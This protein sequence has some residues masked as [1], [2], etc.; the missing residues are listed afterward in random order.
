MSTSRRLLFTLAAPLAAVVFALA[1]SAL[2]LVVSGHNPL[3]AFRELYEYLTATRNGELRNQITIVNRAVPLYLA[4]VAVAI[5]F[6]MNLFNIGVEGQ[7]RFAGLIAA[8]VGASIALPAVIHLPV[9]ILTA[10]LVGALWAGLA[11]LLKVGRGVSEVI[12]TIM[13]NY[14]AFALIQWLLQD[15]LRSTGDAAQGLGAKTDEI[16]ASGR[17]PSLNP[18]FEAIGLDMPGGRNSLYGFLAVAIVLGIAFHVLLNRTRFGYDLRATG[19]NAPAARAAGVKT[20]RMVVQ[21]MVL[22]GAVAGLIGLPQLLGNTYFYDEAFPAGFGF[23][24]IAVALLGRNRPIGMGVAALLFG[25]LNA[26]SGALQLEDIPPEVVK[27]MQAIILLA[28]DVAYEVVRRL[29]EA[30]EVKAA[31]EKLERERDSRLAP[32]GAGV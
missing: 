1:I 32:V 5:G 6:R 4:A 18:V 10:M 16:P 30:A 27:I 25:F 3:V 19:L 21:A 9:I 8:W 22:S 23:E 17:M 29:A 11:G 12:S 14:V 26:A 24:G 13:L 15:H 28:A 20:S 7:Y 31:A 2:V